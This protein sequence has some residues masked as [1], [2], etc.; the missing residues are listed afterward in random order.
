MLSL[1]IILSFTESQ[2]FLFYFGLAHTQ[3]LVLGDYAL[4]LN[5]HMITSFSFM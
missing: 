3:Q 4:T 1:K 5:E 2:I